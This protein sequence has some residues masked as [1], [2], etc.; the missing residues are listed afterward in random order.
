MFRVF[1]Y[2][3]RWKFASLHV[4]LQENVPICIF[5]IEK[6]V[7]RGNRAANGKCKHRRQSGENKDFYKYL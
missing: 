2:A 1:V 5:L 7:F 6:D 3:S 4:T